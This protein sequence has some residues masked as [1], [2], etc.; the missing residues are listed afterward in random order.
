[1][2]GLIDTVPHYQQIAPESALPDVSNLAPFKAVVILEADYSQVWQAEV[3]NWLVQQGCRYMMAWGPN[4]SNW[5]NSVDA[6]DIEGGGLDDDS[7]FVLTTW[8]PDETLESVFWYS[9]FCAIFSCDDVELTNVLILHISETI[10]ESTCLALF[11]RSK[12]LADRE[13]D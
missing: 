9:Q 10:Q 7:K 12:T 3:S 6:A 8:H 5:D 13:L 1:L 11:E 4:C 2:G